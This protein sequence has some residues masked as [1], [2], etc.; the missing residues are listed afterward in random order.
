MAKKAAQNKPLL[1]G[2]YRVEAELLQSDGLLRYLA[3][4]TTSENRVIVEVVTATPEEAAK[5]EARFVQ[6]AQIE[7]P[8]YAGLLETGRTSD[9]Q[10]YLAITV[11]PGRTLAEWLADESTAPRTAVESLTLA[12]QIGSAL[13]AAHNASI[14]HPDLHPQNIYVGDDQTVTLLG[15]GSAARIPSQDG[16]ILDF[17]P[18]EAST[19]DGQ[20]NRGNIYSLGVILYTLL[21]GHAPRISSLEWDIFTESDAYRP[22]PLET[23]K[24]GLAAETYRLVRNCLRRQAWSRFDSMVETLAAIDIA[25][26]AES[27]AKR[28][29]RAPL[30]IANMP[31]QRSW[32]IGGGIV[33]LAVL[34]IGGLLLSRGGDDADMDAESGAP[35]VIAE[36]EAAPMEVES[37]TT[38][39]SATATT[40]SE[41][42]A[43]ENI[44]VL[45]P[46][47]GAEY[48]VED[49]ITFSWRWQRP[50]ISG[51]DFTLTVFRNGRNIWQ[52]T[53]TETAVE[54]DTYR[55]TVNVAAITDTPTVLTWKVQL[56]DDTLNRALF[57]SAEQT[58]IILVRPTPTATSSEPTATPTPENTATPT[59]T[60]TAVCVPTLPPGWIRYTI[61]AE[62][63]L[64]DLATRTGTTTDRLLAVN[65][66]TPDTILSVGQTIFTPPLPPTATPTP[67]PTEP[68]PPGGGSGGGSGGPPPPP[69]PPA[70]PTPPSQPSP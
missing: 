49:T 4:D 62:D 30:V 66:F 15:F 7:H 27:G 68:P 44:E 47:A 12:R 2:K 8:A 16:D 26:Q 38:E 20:T 23:V 45:Q 69:P 3:H 61:Q 60:P 42:V 28:T 48:A 53:V 6:L 59:A 41:R 13:Q 32:L 1:I 5:V 17:A 25:L 55:F 50:L 37:T 33:L 14:V 40:S 9:D 56:E 64:F 34:L 57:E 24:T 52:Q 21:S 36:T 22:A 54:D 70:T 39:I 18:P 43:P 58:L 19:G 31:V 63:T 10:P 51:Q 29:G 11:R 67:E 65:C 46:A 35:A